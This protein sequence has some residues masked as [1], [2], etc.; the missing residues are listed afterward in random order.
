MSVKIIAL[1]DVVG[2]PGRSAVRRR[3]PELRREHN[4]AFVAVNGE[5]SAAGSGLT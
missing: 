4:P 3:L 2:R 1:G 5:N